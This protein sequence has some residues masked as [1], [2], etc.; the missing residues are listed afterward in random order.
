MADFKNNS[1]PAELFSILV[2]LHNDCPDAYIAKWSN[3]LNI[4]RNPE[5]K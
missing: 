5:R 2:S 3:I 1:R 4:L